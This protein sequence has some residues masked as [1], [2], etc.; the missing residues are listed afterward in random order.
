MQPQR[1]FSDAYISG[2]APKRRKVCP[3]LPLLYWCTGMF[4]CLRV[5]VV[6]VVVVVIFGLGMPASL[7]YL[8][9]V[10]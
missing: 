2:M 3:A 4:V 7:L 9:C 10:C 8:V 1:P 5:F 6:V